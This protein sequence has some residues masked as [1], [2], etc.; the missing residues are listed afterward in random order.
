MP[1]CQLTLQEPDLK[2]EP[3]NWRFARLPDEASNPL[4]SRG[5]V[6]VEGELD[7][8][9]IVTTLQPD[10]QGGH[11]LKLEADFIEAT[12][13]PTNHALQFEFSPVKIEPEPNIPEDIQAALS[14]NESSRK[15]WSE[16]TAIAR[17]DWIHWITSGKKVETRQKRIETAIDMLS[18]GKKRAC[19]F[20]RSGMYSKSLTCPKPKTDSK[21]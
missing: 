17:R 21:K 1:Q 19:C 15:T 8:N 3:S 2:G 9:P 16:T 4:P 5:L 18:K 13:L 20:D 6:T 14:Q 11:W 7:G 10:G 12:Q